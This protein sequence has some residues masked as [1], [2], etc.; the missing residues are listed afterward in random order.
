MHILI[1]CL[2]GPTSSSN[3]KVRVW[4]WLSCF[5]LNVFFFCE[6]LIFFF[7][8]DFFLWEITQIHSWKCD[9]KSKDFV[10]LIIVD[11]SLFFSLWVSNFF[12]GGSRSIFWRDDFFFCVG[13]YPNSFLKVCFPDVLILERWITIFLSLNV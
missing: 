9:F 12:L 10:F 3:H 6:F 2:R 5:Q 8:D 1:W 13:N 4:N 7:W 11:R